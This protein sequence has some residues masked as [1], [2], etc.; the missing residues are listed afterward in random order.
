MAQQGVMS[1][2]H[3]QSIGYL[4]GQYAKMRQ[5]WSAALTGKPY[6]MG[7]SALRPEATG[8][9]LVYFVQHI[10]VRHRFVTICAAQ[11]LVA[12][13]SASHGATWCTP[14]SAPVSIHAA[15]L[16]PAPFDT[17]V[18]EGRCE[19]GGIDGKRVAVSGA[20]NV[21]T[22]AMEKLLERG[23][24]PVTM[25]DSSGTVHEPE[26]FTQEGFEQVVQLKGEGKKLSEYESPGQGAPASAITVTSALRNNIRFRGGSVVRMRVGLLLVTLVRDLQQS[27]RG[28]IEPDVLARR[29]RSARAR[30]RPRGM[31]TQLL[32]QPQ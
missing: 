10:L 19:K 26:G 8:Y 21:S 14:R 18:Q 17:R 30:S 27:G 15:Q 25:S 2:R 20:G 12:R 11:W 29:S 5:E 7:G 16:R 23:A 9:G 13:M 1:L 22:Y 24:V 3:V 4:F 28:C 31:R 6:A 32:Q